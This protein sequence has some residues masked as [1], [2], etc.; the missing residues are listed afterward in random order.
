[1]AGERGTQRLE[2][3]AMPAI[4]YLRGEVVYRRHI[5]RDFDSAKRIRRFA[6]LSYVLCFASGPAGAAPI[7]LVEFSYEKVP[8][9]GGV[10]PPPLRDW[11]FGF[12]AYSGPFG[13]KTLFE[14][15]DEYGTDDVGKSFP[16]PMEVVNRATEA[17]SSE[18]TVYLMF[19]AGL[20]NPSAGG[21]VN[22]WNSVNGPCNPCAEILVPN[23]TA[24]TVTAV[25]RVIDKLIVENTG[26]GTWVVGGNQIV[27]FWG[28]PVPEPCT[29]FLLMCVVIARFQRRPMRLT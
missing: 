11:E 16:A 5:L 1:M 12:S 18:S 21:R 26:F 29:Q 25:E 7:P 9:F 24:Y 13:D 27:R 14:W 3:T 22:D 23:V 10:S 15:F 2:A 19:T 28:A 8:Q 17:L 4:R 6:F 20:S